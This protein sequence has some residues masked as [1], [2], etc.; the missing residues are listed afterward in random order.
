[1]L[2]AADGQVGFF[3]AAELFGARLREGSVFALLRDHGARL[4]RDADFAECYSAD[5]GRPSIPPSLLA[6]LLLL[7]HHAGLSD[8]GA[9]DAVCFD[10]RW[11][12]ALGLP[13]DHQGF[14]PTTLVRF[15]ARLLLHGK[16]RLV[17]ERTLVLAVELGLVQGPVEQIVDS[18]PM[19]GAAAVQDTIALVRT[20]V[21]K[22]IDAVA[23]QD[24]QAARDLRE[25]LG[26]D[27][28]HPSRRPECDWR[29]R[30]E[31]QAM[32][33]RVAQDAERA[34]RAVE[35]TPELI[36]SEEVSK[37]ARLL[38]DLIGQDFEVD[39]DGVPR[40]R[41]RASQERIVSA[42]DPE[43]RTGFKPKFGRFAGYKLH[44]AVSN[45]TRPLIC[46]IEVD[47][48]GGHDGAHTSALIDNQPAELRPERILGDTHYGDQTTREEMQQRGIEVLAPV[49]DPVPR[50][51]QLSKR[52]FRID[53]D[54][55]TVTC[56][57]GHAAQIPARADRDGKRVIRFPAARCND[58]P[59]KP[60][61]A[62]YRGG[63]KLT[64][65]KRE[66]LLA[67]G[68]TALQDQ[69]ALEHLRRSR[70]RIERM[71]SLLVVHCHARKSRY[72]GKR[73][74]RLQAACAAALVNLHPIGAALNQQTA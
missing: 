35:Q 46:S 21:R 68:R 44:A 66:D 9:M 22:L 24:E 36:S 64:I 2:T 47:D 30:P 37:A 26:F 43:M 5:R 62:P 41:R 31:R 50:P 27:Y 54:A 57:A 16:E 42:H 15:R 71:I 67:A 29:S 20:G 56:P 45:T 25:G 55:G 17:L 73:K 48:A 59:L 12:A 28:Q 51:G 1:V 8:E 74:A 72:R 13:V 4:V 61:C 34:L 7:Q 52:D 49:P 18:T 39:L 58:C 19:L 33:T 70:P 69:D 3:D 40:L 32:L 38:R 63:R 11:K 23:G 60:R 53:V 65:N 14:H 6:K 10:L